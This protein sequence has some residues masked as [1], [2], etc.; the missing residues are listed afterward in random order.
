[1]VAVIAHFNSSVSPIMYRHNFVKYLCLCISS[2]IR[3]QLHT[4]GDDV[5][6][7]AVANLAFD[8]L[9]VAGETCQHQ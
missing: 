5:A 7:C 9:Q 4:N 3:A 6:T 2:S 8:C 1:M